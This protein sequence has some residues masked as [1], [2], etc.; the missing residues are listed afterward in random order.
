[1]THSWSKEYLA[2]YMKRRNARP[3]IKEHDKKVNKAYYEKNKERLKAKSK[4]RYAR[5]VGK[6]EPVEGGEVK[7]PQIGSEAVSGG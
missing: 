4:A 3:A 1:M 7:Q 2:E 5:L 6:D